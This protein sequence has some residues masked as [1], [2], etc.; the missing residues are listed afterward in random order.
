ME[1]REPST[2]NPFV[3]VQSNGIRPQ[4]AALVRLC[5]RGFRTGRKD[6]LL[7]R[8]KR[9]R[10]PLPQETGTRDDLWRSGSNFPTWWS[11]WESTPCGAEVIIEV[12]GE[13]PFGGSSIHRA[14][15]FPGPKRT[16]TQ[17]SK[18]RTGAEVAFVVHDGPG[19]ACGACQRLHS[20]ESGRGSSAR[21]AEMTAPVHFAV[22]QRPGR[23]K[24]IALFPASQLYGRSVCIVVS[25]R[26]PSRAPVRV[27]IEAAKGTFEHDDRR[28]S[29]PRGTWRDPH[30]RHD[31]GATKRVRRS[32]R[33]RSNAER[34]PTVTASTCTK[35][36]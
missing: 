31:P 10:E 33:P 15:D 19:R 35:S 12:G 26:T 28:V 1:D 24:T 14:G 8:L 34:R 16:F 22:D 7:R 25:V 20:G 4:P 3:V 18:P 23:V 27:M 30:Q 29:T 5:G 32:K 6:S 13:R 2:T 36:W 9:P 11:A 17:R 21:R